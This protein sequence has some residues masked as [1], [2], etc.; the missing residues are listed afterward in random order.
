MKAMFGIGGLIVVAV[1][2]QPA[3]GALVGHWKLD[4]GT[5]TVT[6]EVTG[7]AEAQGTLVNAGWVTTDLAP[8][9]GGTTAALQFDATSS[10]YVSTNYVPVTGSQA[11]TVSCWI[12]CSGDQSANA[13]LVSWGTNNNGQRFSFRLN[14]NA[15]NGVVNAL[16]LEVQGGYKVGQ[17][18]LND[19]T[20][21]HVAVAV[22]DGAG[23]HDAVFYV[24]GVMETQA[25]GLSGTN[26][27]IDTGSAFGLSLGTSLH[28]VAVYLFNGQIDDV[29]V[30]DR[31]LLPE[32][33]AVQ[34]AGG[35]VTDPV[36][37]DR[38]TDVALDATL[39]WT[40]AEDPNNPGQPLPGITG[41]FVYLADD[42]QAVVD[43]GVDDTTG[44]FR[45][46]QAADDL[47]YQ[48]GVDDAAPLM[49]DRVYY[50]RVDT[51][52]VDDANVVRG[53]VWSF[54]T[55]KLKPKIQTHPEDVRAF[56][57]ETATLTVVPEPNQAGIHYQWYHGPAGDTSQPL[58][59][60]AAALVLED[61]QAAD[62]G[63]YWCMLSNEAGDTPSEPAWLAVNRLMG[64]WTFDGDLV[65]A[66]GDGRDG[67]PIG[68]DPN[69]V[70]G[71]DG[72]AV[73]FFE[74]GRL[75]E[76]ADSN[77]V[78]NFY[79]RGITVS[80]WVKTIE[81]GYGAYV[82]KQDRV[83][84][85][86]GFLLSHNGASAIFNIRGLPTQPVAM[87]STP[88]DDNE[89]HLVTGT[90]DNVTGVAR[91]YV[92]G[93]LD[94]ETAGQTPLAETTNRPLVF[95]AETSQPVELVGDRVPYLGALDDVR[96]W[97]YALDAVAVARLYSEMTGEAVCP[98]YPAYDL[99]EDCEVD[100]ADLVI[101]ATNWLQCNRVPVS[102]C[103]Q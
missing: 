11:R 78:F 62:E 12:R 92:D 66:L 52:L 3:A 26:R 14:T 79:P 90:Y 35:S 13:M 23:V 73:E 25:S 86:K 38:A 15:G 74:D 84:P 4:E 75:I 81:P 100:L 6:E 21:H 36:P 43:A 10:A 41:Y 54:Q 55:L 102:A 42:E 96:I 65:S 98:S 60:D 97:N 22:P 49:A 33:I 80:A 93:V 45:G 53:M 69:F 9:P 7:L 61:V 64:H 82:S 70:A 85:W 58:G 91:L 46:F 67:V 101:L 31:M 59:G 1:M 71:V 5:G 2:L 29:R 94:T 39:G 44:V 17:T 57:G 76:V 24:D 34:A 8:V 63:W 27:E 95:G 19:D 83:Q 28:S 77:S 87:G 37:A 68:G 32:E 99:N 48:P 50:W 56:P 51:R 16:R 88:I 20:W 103:S 30:Y 89:W 18:V 47:T 72:M 40:P